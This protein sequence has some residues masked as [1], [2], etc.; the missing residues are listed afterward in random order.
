VGNLGKRRLFGD[1][2]IFY[3]VSVLIDAICTLGSAIGVYFFYFGNISLPDY[4]WHAILIGMGVNFAVFTHLE[5]YKSWR[6]RTLLDQTRTIFI[7]WIIT[8]FILIGL[9]AMLKVSAAYSRM[10]FGLWGIFG[11]IAIALARRFVTT[12][13]RKLRSQG[14]N[15]RR[16]VIFGAGNL[17]Q[18]VA[19][20]VQKASWTG[21][22]LTYFMD[23]DEVKWGT[24]LLGISIVSPKSDL[25][26]FMR[27]N[28]IDEFWIALPLRSDERVSQLLHEIR[29]LTIPVLFIPDIFSFRIFLNYKVSEVEGIATINLNSCPMEGF[30]GILKALEDRILAAVIL[31][32]VGPLMLLIAFAIKITSKGPILFKQRRHGWDGRPINVYKFRTMMVHEEKHGQVTQATKNDPRVT[33]LGRFLRKTSLDELPQ[34]YNVLQG[35]MSIVGPRP[36]AIAH[37]EFYKDQVDHYFQRHQVKPGITGWAQVNG[38][39]G[40]TDTLDKMKKRVEYDLYYIQNW[41]IWFDLKIILLTLFKGFIDRRAY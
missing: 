15:T 13:L 10:W 4:Y 33:P 24:K 2:E 35:R 12:V 29:H 23:D 34:F 31:I 30:N 37:N 6:G 17:G 8:A 28:Y 1:S 40:E 20:R 21:Y 7:G 3:L 27:E 19:E 18:K 36:H 32:L 38:W 16:V 22:H 39:R 41:S 14:W 5:V 11:F 25:V 9:S 26:N